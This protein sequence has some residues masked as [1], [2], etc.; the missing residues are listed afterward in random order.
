M[1]SSFQ[2]FQASYKKVNGKW[3]VVGPP[4]QTWESSKV[5]K[6]EDIIKR[7]DETRLR[8]EIRSRGPAK[9]W[10]NPAFIQ[11]YTDHS[12][13]EE[14]LE[15]IQVDYPDI[16][17]RFTNHWECVLS[18]SPRYAIGQSEE[19]RTLYCLRISQG[20]KSQRKLLKPM[21]KYVANIHGD[22]AVG[23]ELLIGLARL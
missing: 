7:H 3:V 18:H 10:V 11:K 14:I 22:E 4:E 1:L 12:E 8:E 17:E 9:E 19:G 13:M 15:K 5:K 6:I 16:A 23:R 20:V 2:A 21:V